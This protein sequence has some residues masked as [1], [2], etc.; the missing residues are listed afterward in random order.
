MPLTIKE[1]MIILKLKCQLINLQMSIL[2]KNQ[3]VPADNAY[4][5][6][7]VLK[8]FPSE[9]WNEKWHDYF[10][11]HFGIQ[12]LIAIPYDPDIPPLHIFSKYLK[13]ISQ[14]IYVHPCS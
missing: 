13:E 12:N 14:V 1:M 3:N 8:S 9:Y 5:D 7:K 4:D 10:E 6:V 2:K 11:T